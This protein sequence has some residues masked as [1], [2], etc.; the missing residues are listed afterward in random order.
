MTREQTTTAAGAAK[1]HRGL[2]LVA[3]LTTMILVLTALTVVPRNTQESAPKNNTPFLS[4]NKL[5][6]STPDLPRVWDKEEAQERPQFIVCIDPGH[7]GNDGGCSGGG[8]LEKDDTLKMAYLLRDALEAKELTVILT[9][10][11]DEYI[12][13]QERVST[14]NNSGAHYFI[15]LHRNANPDGKGVETWMSNN[16]TEEGEDLA[17]SIHK[18]LVKVGIQKDRGVKQGSQGGTRGDYYVLRF[19]NM[20]AVLIELGFMN[21]STDNY[22]LEKNQEQYAEAIADTVVKVY[23]KHNDTKKDV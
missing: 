13:L 9:R 18:A 3:W 2:R 6:A 14:A 11:K 10:D 20:S 7:G 22:L 17:K 21:N 23:M 16:S 19:T 15:S 4:A 5:V 1:Q 8:R 12:S